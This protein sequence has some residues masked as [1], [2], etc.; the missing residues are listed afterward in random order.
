MEWFCGHYLADKADGADWRVSPLRAQNLAGLAP[1]V[2]CTAWYDPLRDEGVAYAKAL[3][4]AGV[5][6]TQHP[7]F[8]LIHGYFGLGEASDT[9]GAEAQRV[10]ADFKRLLVERT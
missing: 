7:G 3:S 5:P 6:T 2:V 1:A 4:E 8:G 10:R 9:A